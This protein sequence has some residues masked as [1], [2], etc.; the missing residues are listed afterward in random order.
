MKIG[1]IFAIYNCEEFVDDCLNPW[2]NLK[3]NHPDHEF[4]FAVT[5][6]RFSPYVGLGIPDRN[7]GTLA[8]ISAKDIDFL[9]T[10]KGDRVLEED[11]SRNICM[12]Y[13]RPHHCDLI[14][15]VDGDETYT[16]GQILGI[17]DYIERNPDKEGFSLYL[18]NY[19]IQVPYFIPPWSRPTIYRNRIHGGIGRFYFDSFFSY[20]D[21][22]HGIR[23]IELKQIPKSVAFVD[24]FSWIDRQGTRDKIKYQNVRYNIWVQDGVSSEVPE[25]SRCQ[26]ECDEDGIFFSNT[27]HKTRNAPIPSLHEYPTDIIFSPVSFEYQ[28]AENKIE[29]R[30]DYQIDDFILRVKNLSGSRI[31][32]DFNF[33]VPNDR[34]KMWF[35]PGIGQDELKSPDFKGYRLELIKHGEVVH[36]ENILTKI[37]IRP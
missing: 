36:I 26:Y 33:G 37:G 11:E 3:Q 15:L 5:S 24:H 28:R 8:K 25:G 7:E 20:M 17:I 29:I 16:E 35:M 9:V 10:T 13:L 22:I 1:V 6:G 34:I 18:K 32:N 30:S 14:W 2:I 23:D 21:G 12:D 31:Y 19:T 4:I 27:F